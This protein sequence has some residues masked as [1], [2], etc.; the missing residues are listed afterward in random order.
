MVLWQG[1]GALTLG[2][3]GRSRPALPQASFA[4]LLQRKDALFSQVPPFDFIGKKSYVIKRS[5]IWD[6]GPAPLLL[7]PAYLLPFFQTH[8]EHLP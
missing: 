2:L 8:I 7:Y 6:P 5:C 4:L 1:R 3:P